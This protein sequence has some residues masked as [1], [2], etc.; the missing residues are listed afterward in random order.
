M[1]RNRTE[2]EWR[3]IIDGT[4]TAKEI[5]C[6]NGV[7]ICNVYHMAKKYNL[8]LKDSRMSVMDYHGL[9]V[10]QLREELAHMPITAIASKYGFSVSGLISF[11]NRRNIPYFQRIDRKFERISEVPSIQCKRAGEAKDMIRTLCDFYTDASIAR[12]FGCTRQYIYQIRK[13]IEK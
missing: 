7:S 5:A 3:Q 12:V 10:E 2:K 11:A 8:Q 9:P 4:K 6:E 13:G 1:A